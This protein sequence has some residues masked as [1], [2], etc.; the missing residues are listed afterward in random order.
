MKN[1]WK[2]IVISACGLLLLSPPI[3]AQ[4]NNN[5][6]TQERPEFWQANL[7]GGEYVVKT[8]EITAV[9]KHSY[10]VKGLLI[11][12]LN[13]DTTGNSL[14]RIYHIAV[15]GEGSDAN[16]AQNTLAR[17]KELIDQASDRASG[18]NQSDV[19]VKDYPNST[20]A[21]TVEFRV[22]DEDELDTIYSSVKKAW[23]RNKSDT[24]KIE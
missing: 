4:N 21:K 14:L 3:H 12:E 9:S 17:A 8:S 6:N 1:S 13:V 10:I 22:L 24:V 7:P 5:N 15:L 18:Q 19:V 20:H 16:I 11:T 23:R 2:S